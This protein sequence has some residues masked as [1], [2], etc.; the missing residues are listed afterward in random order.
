M[1]VIAWRIVAARRSEKAFTGKGASVDPG[2]WNHE[3][4]PVVYTAAA[5]S[6]AALEILAH[7]TI[8]QL[9]TQSFVAIP[10]AFEDQLIRKI[11]LAALPEEWSGFQVLQATRDIGTIWAQSGASAVLAVPS[12]IIPIEF[13]YLIN[14]RHPDFSRISIGKPETFHFDKRLMR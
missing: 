2:R 10:A 14:P 13:N 1:T 9:A 12:A 11:D 5:L 8:E 4:T 7:A 3:G 6:L